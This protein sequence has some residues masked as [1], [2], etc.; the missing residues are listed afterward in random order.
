[1][2][3]QGRKNVEVLLRYTDKFTAL[4][5]SNLV[6][7]CPLSIGPYRVVLSLPMWSRSKKG[8]PIPEDLIRHPLI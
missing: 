2:P 4:V 6:I 3:V 5:H 1:M 7:W 8:M